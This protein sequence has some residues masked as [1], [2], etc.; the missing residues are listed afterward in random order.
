MGRILAIDYGR[1]RCGIATTDPLKIIA[2]AVGTVRSFEL[3]RF[4]KKYMQEQEVEAIV[5]GEPKQMDATPSES[6]KFIEPFVKKL[7][8]AYP[9]LRIE[10]VDERFT[11]KIAQQAILDAGLKKKQRQNKE[12]VDSVSAVLILQTYMQGLN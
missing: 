8:L 3:L 11:S 2:T 10:R 1:K 5:V 9:D 7:R 12:L 6:A 4:L